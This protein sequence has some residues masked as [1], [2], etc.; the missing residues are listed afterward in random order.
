MTLILSFFVSITQA[1]LVIPKKF[2]SRLRD[3]YIIISGFVRLVVNIKYAT[4]SVE[5]NYLKLWFLLSLESPLATTSK[6]SLGILTINPSS[7]CEKVLIWNKEIELIYIFI[8]CVSLRIVAN[9]H[10]FRISLFWLYWKVL[11]LIE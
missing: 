11:K 9:D 5:V 7:Y 8:F 2:G 1:R 6:L 4:V 10:I 3:L